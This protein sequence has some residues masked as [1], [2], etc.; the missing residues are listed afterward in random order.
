MIK[1]LCCIDQATIKNN[2][3]FFFKPENNKYWKGFG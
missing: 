3:C 2:V 1:N